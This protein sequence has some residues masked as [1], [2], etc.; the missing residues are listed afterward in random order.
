VRD[1]LRYEHSPVFETRLGA[2]FRLLS[3]CE[4]V[5]VPEIMSYFDQCLYNPPFL[6]AGAEG[7]LNHALTNAPRPKKRREETKGG[8]IDAKV[9]KL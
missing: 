8:E 9:K 2:L 3:I 6:A 7:G 5:E 1:R 4:A